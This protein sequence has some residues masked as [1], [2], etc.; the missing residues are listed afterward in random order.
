MA[1]TK[2]RSF[3]SVCFFWRAQLEVEQFP[4][5][6]AQKLSSFLL[7]FPSLSSL[8]PS[9]ATASFTTQL[10]FLPFAFPF[11]LFS[12]ARLFFFCFFALHPA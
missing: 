2:Q 1:A 4:L 7:P 3:G 5:V 11:P 10:L 8:S 9:D 12:C 6:P